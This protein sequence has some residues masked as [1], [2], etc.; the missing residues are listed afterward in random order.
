ME[1]APLPI[2]PGETERGRTPDFT[3]TGLLFAPGL[4]FVLLRLR[5]GLCGCFCGNRLGREIGCNSSLAQPDQ[6]LAN[7][8]IHFDG[9]G[10]RLHQH[11]ADECIAGDDDSHIVTY[12][13][14]SVGETWTSPAL[15]CGISLALNWIASTAVGVAAVALGTATSG[16]T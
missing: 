12:A 15:V 3:K 2:N 11:P 4:G 8:R 5:L 13:V 9:R 6:L 16:R 14:P 1:P 7:D 10:G